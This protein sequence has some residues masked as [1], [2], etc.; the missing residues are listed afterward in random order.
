LNVRG[1]SAFD[2]IASSINLDAA[3]QTSVGRTLVRHTQMH[4]DGRQSGTDKAESS[5]TMP[6]VTWV[7]LVAVIIVGIFGFGVVLL[8]ASLLVGDGD[9]RLRMRS[10]GRACRASAVLLAALLGGLVLMIG[11]PGDL[12]ALGVTLRSA[13][14][15]VISATLA[16]GLWIA[17]RRRPAVR[18]ELD[19][20]PER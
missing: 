19:V 12:G 4:Q 2:G 7:Q 20:E 10:V 3:N 14:V 8:A 11:T 6:P 13:G 1:L 18:G 16:A 5:A 15:V 17:R 9:R